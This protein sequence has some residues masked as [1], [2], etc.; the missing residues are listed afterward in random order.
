MPTDWIQI[1]GDPSIRRFLFE[2]ERSSN[3]FDQQIDY[4]LSSV[5]KL[6]YDYGVF[7]AKVHFSSGQVTLWFIDDPLRYKVY[8]KD[9]FLKLDAAVV[10]GRHVYPCEA[11]LDMHMIQEVFE[12]FKQLRV[13]D[14][15]V[16]LRSGSINIINGMV[17]L[18]FSC[19]GSHYMDYQEFIARL[20]DI[21]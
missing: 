7:H 17:G 10:Y 8:V 6:I 11:Q 13:R 18:N 3:E 16:Y 15:Q 9:E 5:S 20:E 2:Q 21:C 4:V 14:P 1:K 12:G 19:D